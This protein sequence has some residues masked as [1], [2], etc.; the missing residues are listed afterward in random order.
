MKRGTDLHGRAVEGDR[1]LKDV[2]VGVVQK[3]WTN[4]RMTKGKKN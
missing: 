1:T 4:A 3:G 2:I